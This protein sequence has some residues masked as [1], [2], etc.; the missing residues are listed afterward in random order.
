MQLDLWFVFA[1]KVGNGFAFA[2]MI[3]PRRNSSA[4]HPL[5]KQNSEGLRQPTASC[6]DHRDT[7]K[8]S[9]RHDEG[10]SLRLGQILFKVDRRFEGRDDLSDI[11]GKVRGSEVLLSLLQGL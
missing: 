9:L 5:I 4:C 8:L 11:C 10:E 6:G 1:S 3:I 7:S 2:V